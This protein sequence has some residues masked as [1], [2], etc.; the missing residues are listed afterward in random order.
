MVYLSYFLTD[1]YRS[2][3]HR[4]SRMALARQVFFPPMFPSVSVSLERVFVTVSRSRSSSSDEGWLPALTQ[5]TAQLFIKGRPR[6]WLS[7][8]Q[9]CFPSWVCLLGT[10][11][12]SFFQGLHKRGNP[13]NPAA[14][15]V[16]AHLVYPVFLM[17]VVLFGGGIFFIPLFLERFS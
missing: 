10:M 17:S 16:T 11:C 9:S 15:F 14:R 8:F 1:G 7:C 12:S 13:G 4:S 6:D 5:T 3:R 2:C